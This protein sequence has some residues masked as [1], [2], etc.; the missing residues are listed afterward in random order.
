MYCAAQR[1]EP[2]PF[3][4]IYGITSTKARKSSCHYQNNIEFHHCENAPH[5]FSLKNSPSMLPAPHSAK[6]STAHLVFFGLH[7]ETSGRL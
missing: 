5:F 7:L 1:S 3:P 4:G 2:I 6:M